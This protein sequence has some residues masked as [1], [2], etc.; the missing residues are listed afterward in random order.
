M[1]C[2]HGM[3]ITPETAAVEAVRARHA[4]VSFSCPQQIATAIEFAASFAFDNGAFN[5]W[6]KGKPIKDW[7]PFYEWV[8]KYRRVPSLDW[9]VIPDVIDGNEAD[10]DALL[11]EWPFS[12]WEGAPVW[13]LHESLDRLAKLAADWPRVCLGSSAEYKTVGSPL[14]EKR[15]DAAMA[16]VCDAEGRPGVKLHGLRMLSVKVFPRFPFASADSTNVGRNVGID[17]RWK[18]PYPP[19]GKEARAR[20]IRERIEA[21]NA[22]AAYDLS[23]G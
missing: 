13:H 6:K 23:L 12:K 2:Y 3:P 16:V 11:R 4:F 21:F 20:V 5:A 8:G 14:W 7:R 9:T 17:A 22:P 15:M 10:N 19:A 18:G 1:I